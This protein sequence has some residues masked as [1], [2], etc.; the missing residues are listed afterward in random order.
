M[1][2]RQRRADEAGRLLHGEEGD[3]GKLADLRSRYV[4]YTLWPTPFVAAYALLYGVRVTTVRTY[5]LVYSINSHVQYAVARPCSLP[6]LRHPLSHCAHPANS[7][8]LPSTTTGPRYPF[9]CLARAR[10]VCE[11]STYPPPNRLSPSHTP[12]LTH[13]EFEVDQLRISRR[14]RRTT[15]RRPLNSCSVNGRSRG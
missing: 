10:P 12:N 9:P 6:P 8:S 11:Q 13:A 15:R 14:T 2:W 7:D 5:T 1:V 4:A 3:R